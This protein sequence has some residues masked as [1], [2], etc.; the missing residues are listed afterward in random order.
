MP[1]EPSTESYK[2]TAITADGQ[3]I[4]RVFAATTVDRAAAQ[5]WESIGEQA[6]AGVQVEAAQLTWGR[7]WIRRK[8]NTSTTGGRGSSCIGQQGSPSERLSWKL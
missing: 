1:D 3:Q 6:A 7:G 2:F 8:W 5:G 4:E